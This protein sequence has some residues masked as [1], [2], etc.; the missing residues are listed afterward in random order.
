MSANIGIFIIRRIINAI[1]TLILLIVILFIL[2]HI[3]APSPLALAR[4]YAANPHAPYSEL[5]QII[6]EYGLNK[7]LYVQIINYI[8]NVLHG[9]LGFD[10][11]YK[12]PEIS[13]IGQYLPITLELVIPATILAVVIGLLSG[14]VAASNRNKPLDYFVK[15]VYLVTWASPPFLVATALLIF[16][17][18]DLHLLPSNG[19]VNPT[20]TAPPKYTPFPVLNSIVAGD[21]TYFASLVH[22][23][24]LPVLSLSLVSFGIVTRLTRAS[25]LD[26]MDTD[27]ARLSLMKGLSRRRVIYGVV[28]RNASIPLITLIALLFGYSVAGAVVIEDIYHYFGMGYFITQAIF[29]LDY[30]AILDTT[31]IIGISIIAANLIADILYGVVDPRVRL[32]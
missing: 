21:W 31:L 17:A 9:N 7:P 13:L 27:F 28:L 5:D 25:M 32:E 19:V 14:A 1:I 4:I 15:G 3:I 11:I 6:K 26:Y 24:V 23:M 29:N 20:L 8:I 30:I 18:F 22:H 10:P 12:V 16:F 2:I